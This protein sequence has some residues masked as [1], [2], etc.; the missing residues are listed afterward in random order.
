MLAFMSRFATLSSWA[1]GSERFLEGILG[2]SFSCAT[3]Y[4]FIHAGFKETLVV[5]LMNAMFSPTYLSIYA[6]INCSL[7]PELSETPILEDKLWIT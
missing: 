4:F 2:D 3:F 1:H 5:L 6:L 7:I